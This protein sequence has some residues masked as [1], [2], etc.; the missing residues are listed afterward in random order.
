[1]RELCARKEAAAARTAH[2]FPWIAV[3]RWALGPLELT[4][5]H[6]PVQSTEAER[7]APDPSLNCGNLQRFALQL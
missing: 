4:G 1:M 3:G 7:L 5:D 6:C 2:T